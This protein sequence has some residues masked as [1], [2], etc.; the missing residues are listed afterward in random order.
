[1]EYLINAMIKFR[2]FKFLL[3]MCLFTGFMY[4]SKAQKRM[5]CYRVC[6]IEA[7]P[8]YLPI[9]KGGAEN[10]KEEMGGADI[11]YDF[12]KSGLI[13][14]TPLRFSVYREKDVFNPI[15]KAEKAH[16]DFNKLKRVGLVLDSNNKIVNSYCVD[17]STWNVNAIETSIPPNHVLNIFVPE[18]VVVC[19]NIGEKPDWAKKNGFSYKYY[20]RLEIN[21]KPFDWPITAY[22]RVCIPAEAPEYEVLEHH[23]DDMTKYFCECESCEC[24][25]HCEC[26]KN[27]GGECKCSLCKKEPIEPEPIEEEAEVNPCECPLCKC[28][29]CNCVFG[30]AC[31]C[32]QLCNPPIPTRKPNCMCKDC[33]CG[34]RCRCISGQ[35]CKC[36]QLCNPPIPTHKPQSPHKHKYYYTTDAYIRTEHKQVTIDFPD[37]LKIEIGQHTTTWRIRREKYQPI[38][39]GMDSSNM[40]K[41]LW[42]TVCGDTLP[43]RIYAV[44]DTTR[45]YDLEQNDSLIFAHK[46]NEM[47]LRKDVYRFNADNL[48]STE[49]IAVPTEKCIFGKQQ[50]RISYI[51]VS[52]HERM[53]SCGL[54]FNSFST[55][56]RYDDAD[57]ARSFCDWLNR[58]H[59]RVNNE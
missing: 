1:M 2:V 33:K 25:E 37:K 56:Y 23:S 9:S 51:V 10:E 18:G 11:Y 24:G 26:I 48:L 15:Y 59:A 32:G 47:H 6:P 14:Y 42:A 55:E 43:E 50:I 52:P 22:W 45:L 3:M 16:V 53:C 8:M 31:K 35:P 54:K 21:G 36:G 7:K 20:F 5:V 19:D 12:R 17:G 34:E 27:M 40:T 4:E 28:D 44:N 46:L 57:R 13:T 41:G 30:Q 38:Y 58:K 39:Y 49:F 29:N